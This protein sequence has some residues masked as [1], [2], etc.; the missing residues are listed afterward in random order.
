MAQLRDSDAFARTVVRLGELYFPEADADGFFPSAGDDETAEVRAAVREWVAVALPP[1]APWDELE[2]VATAKA[3]RDIREVTG[4]AEDGGAAIREARR[5]YFE[6]IGLLLT[7]PPLLTPTEPKDPGSKDTVV[8]AASLVAGGTVP[9]VSSSEL[10]A[11]KAEASQLHQLQA[12]GFSDKQANLR[13]LQASGGVVQA[14]V[15]RL[16]S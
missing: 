15:E 10:Q 3:E 7:A 14:A 12:M 6:D 5:K 9:A 2:E 8:V 16:L 1:A 4:D 13:A 11:A